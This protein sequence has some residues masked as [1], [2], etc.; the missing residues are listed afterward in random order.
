MTNPKRAHF[1]KAFSAE[2][3]K[4]ATTA[5]LPEAER[6][7]VENVNQKHPHRPSVPAPRKYKFLFML[8]QKHEGN[9]KFFAPRQGEH[10]KTCLE[11]PLMTFSRNTKSPRL[12][13]DIFLSFYHIVDRKIVSIIL[14]HKLPLQNLPFLTRQR[15]PFRHKN[16]QNSATP[17]CPKRNSETCRPHIQNSL[18]FGKYPE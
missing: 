3:E 5:P 17:T 4:E 11:K 16:F 2:T 6:G 7:E 15:Y 14:S 13:K 8:C 18:F 12:H 9:S 10:R 1:S